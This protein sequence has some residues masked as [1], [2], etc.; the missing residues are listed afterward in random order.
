MKFTVIEVQGK[1]LENEFIKLPVGLYKDEPF[2]IRPLDKDVRS[3]FDRNQNKYFERGECIRW[4]LK[5]ENGEFI[6]RIAAFTLK[7]WQEEP[8]DVPR[9]GIGFF[10][11]IHNQ[12][13]ANML[14]EHS[15]KWL[16]KRD[17]QAMDGPVNF[18]DR[19]RWWGCLVDGFDRDP[20]YCMPYNFP[21]Y[22]EL[23][24][25][26]GFQVLFEQYTF[27]KN[28]EQELHPSLAKRAERIFHH[29]E[30]T[31]AHI[32][33]KNWRRHALEFQQV[34]NKAWSGHKGVAQ[35]SEEHAVGLMKNALP[36]LDEEMIWFGYFEGEPVCFYI[37]LPEVNQ[38][39]KHVNGKLDVLGR[40]KFLW[41][42]I[43]KTNRKLLGLVFG[44]V[45]EH[46]GKGLESALILAADTKVRGENRRYDLLEFNWIGDF[47]PRMIKLLKLV[48]CEPG[49]THITYRFMFDPNQPVKKP[50]VLV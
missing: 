46:Q 49:K 14:F 23:F 38:I 45:P 50:E 8:D 25:N 36:I 28:L 3:V 19:D 20:N 44:V 32:K 48:G 37:N 30:Y 47:N 7:E 17:I 6:G 2:Y 29:S 18:G 40:L 4:L 5:N 41:H 11:C 15:K 39:F 26:F 9:G 22:R 21:Y 27:A 12:D 42:Q 33:K 31:F 43:L 24:E 16:E 34:Y 10:D 35:M 13:A 1:E